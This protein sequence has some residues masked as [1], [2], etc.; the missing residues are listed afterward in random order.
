MSEVDVKVLTDKR[1]SELGRFALSRGFDDLGSFK[2]P[3]LRNV[4]VT[5]PYFHDGSQ[6]ELRDV[7]VHYNNGGVTNEGDR[8]NDFL[9]GG[10]RPLD[11]TDEQMDAL[12]L[13]FSQADTSSNLGAAVNVDPTESDVRCLQGEAWQ[14][15]FRELNIRVLQPGDELVEA[16][17]QSRV[18]RALPLSLA[19]AGNGLKAFPGVGTLA[20]GAMH[21]VAYGIIFRTLGRA[22][23]TT[24]AT[25]GE[26]HPRQTAKLFE[27]KLGEDL[28]TPARSLARLVVER[29]RG[30][31]KH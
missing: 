15:P 4:A 13:P 29:A 6:K 19:V 14:R 18:G 12:F 20:G 17:R 21:A 8:V 7:V 5:A 30:T 1:T 10:V 25:R 24:L 11:L 22:L 26:L 3:T 16:V 2:T 27:E 23:T 28:E 31:T 9:S